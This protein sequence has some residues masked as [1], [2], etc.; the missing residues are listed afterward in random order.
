MIELR[1]SQK[2]LGRDAAPVETGPAGALFLNAGDL[3]PKLRRPDRTHIARR[4]AADNDEIV[5][6]TRAEDATVLRG[7]SKFLAIGAFGKSYA[8]LT[9]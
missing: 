9:H 2:R 3:F 4:S 5:I 6:H 7:E 1:I 8:A